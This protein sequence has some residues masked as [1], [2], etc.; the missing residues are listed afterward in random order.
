[1]SEP[2]KIDYELL[3]E[4]HVEFSV[5]E[6]LNLNSHYSALERSFAILKHLAF[7]VLGM[8]LI[9]LFGY[10]LNDNIQSKMQIDEY[11]YRTYQSEI[12]IIVLSLYFLFLV[13]ISF[14]KPLRNFWLRRCFVKS[15]PKMFS[16]GRNKMWLSPSTLTISEDEILNQTEY[17]K[18][19]YSWEVVEKVQVLE[20]VLEIFVASIMAVIVPK[21]FFET[22][23]EFEEF[24]EAAKRLYE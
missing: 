21:R 3:I 10:F 24:F 15:F 9:L 8:T 18:S 11:L 13:S 17:S 22:E 16:T 6:N 19:H 2:L 5:R 14:L 20:G 12:F 1:M 23:K 7:V 4:D